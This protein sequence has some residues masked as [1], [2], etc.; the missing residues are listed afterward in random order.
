MS[1]FVDFANAMIVQRFADEGKPVEFML[2]SKNAKG[3]QAVE[4]VPDEV[5][6]IAQEIADGVPFEALSDQ[7][8]NIIEDLK[9]VEPFE[10]ITVINQFT[11]DRIVYSHHEMKT[12]AAETTSYAEAMDRKTGDCDNFATEKLGLI[13]ATGIEVDAAYFVGCVAI[14]GSQHQ[15]SQERLQDMTTKGGG[16]ALA[17]VSINGQHYVLDSNLREPALLTDNFRVEGFFRSDRSVQSHDVTLEFVPLYVAPAIGPDAEAGQFYALPEENLTYSYDPD[18]VP[19][20]L[21]PDLI[22]PGQ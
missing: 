7:H 9:S 3:H 8:Q 5:L 6:R 22:K 17:V 4:G 14:Y 18:F 12:E 16:H 20:G 21:V 1:E 19:E 15:E 2:G 11:N 10:A 13:K